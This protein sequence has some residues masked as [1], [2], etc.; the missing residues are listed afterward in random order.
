MVKKFGYK[1]PTIVALTLAGTAFSA[2][3]ANAAEQ[4]APEKT[5][6][7]VLDDQYALKQADDAKQTT[8]GTTLA[9]SKEYKDPSQIDTAQVDTAAQTETRVEEGQQDAQQPATTDE[10]TSTDHTVSKSTDESASPATASID[11]GTLNAQANSDETANN[12]T[13]DATEDANK[14]PYRSSEIDTH[15]DATVSPDTYHAPDTPAQQPSATDVSDSTT[16]QTEATQANTSTNVNDKEAVATTENAAATQPQAA[17]QSEAKATTETAQNK[18]PQVDTKDTA[19]VDSKVTATQN[20]TQSAATNQDNTDK[21]AKRALLTNETKTDATTAKTEAPASATR[22]ADAQ[23]KTTTDKKATTY[24]AQTATDK[25]INANPD[26]P[27]P[28]RVGGKGGPP[29]SLSLQSTGHQTAFRSAVA[30]KPSAYQPKVKSSINDYIRKQNYKVPVYEEDY[31]SYFPKYGYRNGVGKPEGIIVHDTANDRSTIDGEISYMKRN[32]QNAF[33]HGFING[34]RIIETQPTDYLAWGA[35]AIANERFIHI[36]L[37]HVHSKEDFARQMNNM[38]DYAATNL[39]YYGLAPDSAEYDGRGTVWTHDAVSRFLGGTDHTDPHGYLKQH[40]YSYDELYDLINEKY[41]VKMGYASPANSSSKPS[42]PST[43]TALKVT[44]DTGLGRIKDKNSGLYVTVYDKTGKS[45]SAT[46]Q[47]LKVTKKASLNGQ[48]FYLVTDYATG[49][50]VGWAKQAD[51]EY[52]TSKAPSKVSKNYTIK[53]GAKLYQV[54]WGTSKQVAGTVTG[55]ATQ[56]FKTTLS[57]TVGKA[58]YLYGTV[59]KLSGWINASSVVAND[60]KPSTNTALKVTTDTGLGRIKDKNSGLYATVYDKTGKSTSAT[61]QTL[62]VTKKA[63]LN[64]QS[65]Y[66]VTDY[67]TGTYVGWAKQADVEYQTSK[68]P[69]KVSQNYTIKSGAKLYQVP[70]GTSKQVAGTVTGAATQTFKTTLSQTV[71]KATYLYGT[72]GKLS[73]WINSTALTVQ[74]AAASSVTKAV[75]QIG[76]L[77]TKNSGIKA[78]IYDKTAKSAARWAGQTYKITKTASANNEDYVLLQNNTGGTPL[79]WFYA[80]DVTTRSLGAETAIKGNYTVNSKTS[81]LYAMP[82]GTT[83]QRVDTL[84]NAASRLFTASKSVKVGNDT[85]LFGTVNQKLGWINQKDLTAVAAKVANIKTASNSAVKGAAIT[86]LKKVEDYVITNKNGYYYTKVGDSKSAGALKGF[87][88][89]LFKV[90]K[91]SLLNGITWYYGAF[92]N[93]TKGWI[94]AADVR[95]SFIQHTAVSST[96]KAALHKQMA[97]TYPPQVQRVAGK[98]V[99]ANRVE[100]EKAMNT[101][102]LEKDPTLMYQFLK[103]DQYQ[104]LGAEELNKLLRGKGILEG[105]GAAFKEAAQKHNINEV[106]LMSHAFLETGNGTS[107][108]ANG[109]H[110]DKNNKVVTTG[111]PKYYNMFGIGAIDTDALR[112]GFKTAERYGWN[113]VSKAIIGGAKFIRDQYIGSGQNT[114]YRMRWNPEHP[115]THQYATDINWANVNAQRMKYFYD[116]IGETGKYFDVDVYK[117]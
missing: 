101:A 97:L 61:N 69:S 15:E 56:T 105:Q 33:V 51:V 117:K 41:Q 29:A 12:R 17:V 94:K 42:K 7:N 89:Q 79:G 43:N 5:P 25:D 19:Q 104:G 48:S 22:Q 59:G 113:T 64:G 92:Q 65:F 116:Q 74:K 54:P 49:T 58:T 68:A 81:G 44:T 110:V 45:T 103:L 82:W 28:P 37:V 108:L 111:K 11:E 84:K 27:T 95:S 71:G 20:T 107:Q 93:G 14:Y 87:Y 112:N 88:Q 18:T 75:S 109:G 102:A 57:Q 83:K 90:E 96:L 100:T 24:N 39:Q 8:Q 114:L 26:G 23:A 63:S 10:A 46:N 31:S 66:L 72:V 47:T 13:Q 106:Y 86:T 1:T 70:W 21:V 4:V 73:G 32:Y 3:Q 60:Q 38:A 50:Y 35:G 91:S 78:S 98:W 6:T 16:T 36:E 115:A 67:A 77:N 55:A 53:S 40:G 85:F 30:S 52:Q 9:G 62:K 80:K 99:N 34:Q 76:Q 2:H